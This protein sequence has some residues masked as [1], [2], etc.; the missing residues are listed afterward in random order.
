MYIMVSLLAHDPVV[1]YFRTMQRR[2]YLPRLTQRA[3][4]LAKHVLAVWAKASRAAP[5]LRT[6]LLN[7][8]VASV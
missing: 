3:E 1:L 4:H 2:A 6:I 7:L 5:L 8:I